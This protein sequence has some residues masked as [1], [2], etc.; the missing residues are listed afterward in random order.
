MEIN[1]WMHFTG[2]WIVE[3]A[4]EVP[5]S[6]QL[7]GID[8]ESRLFPPVESRPKNLD[9]SIHS[10]LSLPPEWTDRFTVVHQRLLVLALR[11]TEWPVA[12]KELYRVTRPGGWV[13]LCEFAS[14]PKIGL[15]FDCGQRL[16]PMLRDAGFVDVHV[17][18]RT[19]PLGEWGGELGIMAQRNVVTV[20]RTMMPTIL[21]AARDI[22]GSE[23][24]FNGFID[25]V[26]IELGESESSYQWV[27]CLG[28][29]PL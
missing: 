16:E 9:F 15:Q 5:D 27:V 13:Q 4:D 10:V 18:S 11:S 29:K 20:W 19:C 12:L 25:R 23:E 1:S 7:E 17:D 3:V 24:E 2:H 26:E 14:F 6:V 22:W 28:R 21:N 8:I